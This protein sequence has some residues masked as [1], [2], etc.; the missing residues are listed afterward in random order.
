MYCFYTRNTTVF[1]QW[2][3]FVVFRYKRIHISYSWYFIEIP[4]SSDGGFFL[5]GVL[6]VIIALNQVT[7]G[8]LFLLCISLRLPASVQ[9]FYHIHWEKKQSYCRYCKGNLL[10]WLVRLLHLFRKY[11][12]SR[13]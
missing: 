5:Y 12:D 4:P 9:L 10:V 13:T 7:P 11:D 2:I 6:A 3:L 8:R 1:K